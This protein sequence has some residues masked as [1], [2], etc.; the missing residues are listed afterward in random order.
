MHRP[1]V[2]KQT[3]A[4]RPPMRHLRYYS[5]KTV[6]LLVLLFVAAITTPIT[7]VHAGNTCRRG[8]ISNAS[9]GIRCG[10]HGHWHCDGRRDGQPRKGKNPST[11]DHFRFNFFQSSK[12][13]DVRGRGLAHFLALSTRRFAIMRRCFATMRRCKSAS[14]THRDRR[15]QF[16]SIQSSAS[17]NRS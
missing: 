2:L 13:P 16:A 10:H 5:P 9:F 12:P 17:G 3:D 11:R 7:A 14:L 4:S 15:P 8:R 6:V 1:I